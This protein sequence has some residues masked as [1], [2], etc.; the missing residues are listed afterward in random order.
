MDD[1]YRRTP[2]DPFEQELCRQYLQRAVAS[3]A[4]PS[5]RAGIT[6]YR[7][8]GTW[9]L[10]VFDPTDTVPTGAPI[11]VG[12]PT[13]ADTSK[14]VEGRIWMEER[15]TPGEDRPRILGMWELP[16]QEGVPTAQRNDVT[17]PPTVSWFYAHLD[18][19]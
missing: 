12:I 13:P 10:V 9:A 15:T 7:G 5:R 3:W 17:Y 4:S 8:D 6:E 2:R 14:A 18:Q 11:T 16:P 19:G 1:T